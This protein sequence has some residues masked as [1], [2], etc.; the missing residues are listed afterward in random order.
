MIRF[1]WKG[2]I[3]DRSRSLFPMLIVMAGASLTVLL[4]CWIGGVQNDMIWSYAAF[5][6]GH[7]KIMTRAYA[8][9]V[10]QLPNDLALMGVDTLMQT[11]QK[12]DPQ[13][14]WLPRIRFGGL[15][16]IPDENKET[17]SQAPVMGL[18]V[19]LLDQKSPELEI[20]NLKSALVSGR[21]P[22]KHGDI[23]ITDVLAKQLKISLGQEATLIG[24]TMYGAMAM[25][26][27]KIVGTIH[28]G[29]M[30]MDR[31]AMIA[32]IQDVQAALNMDNAA[33]EIVGFFADH[34]YTDKIALKEAAQFNAM[35]SMDID[36]FVPKMIALSQQNGLGDML[37][38]TKTAST[39][40]ITIFVFV[41]SLVLWN[42]GLMGSIRRYGEIGVRLA[43]GEYK[44][45]VYRSLIYESLMIGFVG[46]IAGT[47]LGLA[48]SYYLQFHGV[49]LGGLMKNSTLL[50]S[51]VMRA[52]V[53]P[54]SYF[55]AFLPGFFAPLLG[56][57]ISG[58]GIYKRQTSQLFKELEV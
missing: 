24:S 49:N 19:R 29:M 44:G 57:S 40:M 31:G 58:I 8:K 3:R 41:M 6:S 21:L 46:A 27:F 47:A 12:D 36:E 53:T 1:L 54:A 32:D 9:Q 18:G 34:I 50:V 43:M 4:Y 22:E 25:M 26:N 39:F 52:R 38:M 13:M 37:D 16:D 23:L 28:F 45:H 14:I 51:E 20:L 10:D 55:I 17:K 2:L 42:T 56:T 35:Y 11:L 7:V 15:L 5:Q 33:S 48:A 30:A